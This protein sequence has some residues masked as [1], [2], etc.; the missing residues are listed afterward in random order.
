M[1][2]QRYKYYILSLIIGVT[3][4]IGSQLIFVPVSFPQY[5]TVPLQADVVIKRL[6]ITVPIVWSTSTKESDLQKDLELGAIRYPGTPNPGDSGNS[7]I[8]AHSSGYPW[9]QGQY[10]TAFVNLGK[11][12]VGDDDIVVV[13]TK[14]GLP[15]YRA[16][17]TVMSK[18]V[19]KATDKRM[20]EQ[21]DKTE[22]TLVTCWPIGTNLLRLMV[23]TELV[24]IETI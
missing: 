16:K 1:V 4:Y 20:I 13:Y 6:G 7:F 9:Q 2:Y 14:D 17:F 23:K 18:E 11:L 19:V 21:K 22:M 8:T 3:A 24:S 5:N 15:V 12:K 10:K